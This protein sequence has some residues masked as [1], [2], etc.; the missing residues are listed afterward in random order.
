MGIYSCKGKH[1]AFKEIWHDEGIGRK[2]VE[3]VIE[4]DGT[5]EKHFVSPQFVDDKGNVWTR[6]QTDTPK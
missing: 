6:V 5:M 1:G 3:Y 2:S 4:E